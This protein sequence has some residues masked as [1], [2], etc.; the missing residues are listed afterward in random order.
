MQKYL[1]IILAFIQLNVTLA[2]QSPLSSGKWVKITLS[3]TGVHSISYE[4]LRQMGFDVATIDP[5]KIQLF[6]IPGGMLPQR[7]NADWPSSLIEIPIKRVTQSQNRLAPGDRIYFYA[8]AVDRLHYNRDEAIFSMEKNLYADNISYF[9]TVSNVDGQ[10]MIESMDLGEG[11]PT[12]DWHHHLIHHEEELTNLLSSGRE[13]YGERITNN[14]LAFDHSVEHPTDREAKITLNAMAQA[15]TSTALNIQVNE[16]NE[17]LNFN[18][19]PNQQYTIKGNDQ[20]LTLP[21]QAT[22]N[23]NIQINYECNGSSNA[24]AYLNRY[25]VQIP[26]ENRFERNFLLTNPES[27]AQSVSEFV[28]FSDRQLSIWNVTDP[29]APMEQGIREIGNEL[30]FSTFTDELQTFWVFDPLSV[31]E[32]ERFE[33]IDNQNLLGASAPDFI[34]ISHKLFM[35]QAE[36]MAAFRRSH[37]QMNVLVTTLEK[38]YNEFSAGRPDLTAIRNFIRTKY[39]QSNRLQY[40]L[41]F[42]KGSY[43]YKERVPANT[44]FIPTYESRN[45]LHP[46]FSFSSDDYFGFLEEDEGEWVENRAGD[47][48]LEVGIG[49]IPITSVEQANNFVEKWKGYQLNE[50]AKGDWR[51][52]LTFVADD[53]DRNIHQRDADILATTVESSQPE[54]EVDKL[55]LDAYKQENLPNGEASP[56]AEQALHDAVHEGRLLINFTGHGAESG[57]MQERILTFQSME[58][59]NNPEKLPFLVTATCEFGRNDDPGTLSGAEYL[60]TKKQSGTIGLVTTARPVF[61]STNFTLNEALYEIMLTV[62]NG[63]YQR[64]GDIIKYTKNNSLEGSIN[65]NFI[66]LGDPSMRLAIPQN[67]IE[68]NEINGTAFTGQDT[69]RALE[70]ITFSGEIVDQ[71]TFTGTLTYELID[72]PKEKITLGT[73]SAPFN[74]TEKDQVLARGEVSVQNG[75]FQITT[76]IPQNI[77][78][79]FDRARL[80]LFARNEDKSRD[81]FGAFEE[82]ILGG[83]AEQINTDNLPP[84]GR[85][86]LNDTS[87]QFLTSYPNRVRLIALLEDESGINIS[88]NALGQDIQLTI[89]DSIR[90]RLNAYYEHL[91]DQ[92]QKGMLTFSIEDLPT[93]T[94]HLQLTFWDNRGNRNS[95]ELTF[96]VGENSPL[97]NEIKNYPNPLENE[98]NFFIAHQLAGDNLEVSIQVFDV[99]GHFIAKK[100]EQINEAPPEV[101]IT[102]DIA[103]E[104]GKQLEKGVYI[105]DIHIS[106]R[107]S[108]LSESKRKKLIISY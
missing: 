26:I 8:D 2:Q 52:K 92:Y 75:L 30:R 76:Q 54:F 101:V 88:S 19:I 33:E 74:F 83:T 77:N 64:L 38:V 97:I 90:Y 43:D 58:Q 9:I 93:G 79:N 107:L 66:L 49:R 34:I 108:G 46:L 59:W 81:A 98:T 84:K 72:K 82:F 15:F 31:P 55:Y 13:W 1:L 3:E 73:E 16:E 67:K 94:N 56:E 91:K 105:Y 89:N 22:E 62:E 37:D 78:Y 86:F 69:I 18:S 85:L 106:S 20:T 102:W 32:P 63:Q 23:I 35:K 17:T 11:F 41:L 53:G 48:D 103:S 65:R 70:E 36:E 95:Q 80:Q 5:S 29:M 42:G 25:L 14:T 6:G 40:I 10:T 71:P 96:R 51:T 27:L 4:K 44:N 45:S 100:M 61:S 104:L 39:A 68:I 7:N 57:W 50:S 21:F 28:I 47:H 99:N 24:T 12:Y 60:L 87:S